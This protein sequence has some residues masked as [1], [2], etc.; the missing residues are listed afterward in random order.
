MFKEAKNAGIDVNVNKAVVKCKVFEDNEGAAEIATVH[1]FRPRTK[2]IHLKYHHFREHVNS[3][4]V[5][6][7]KVATDEQL[8][9]MFTKPLGLALFRKHRKGIMGW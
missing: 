3:G 5:W 2:H 8:A 7:V 4:L 1:K 6:I 9:D